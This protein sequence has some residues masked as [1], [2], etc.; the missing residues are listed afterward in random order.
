MLLQALSTTQEPS[1]LNV[2]T[3]VLSVQAIRVGTVQT[4]TERIL[5]DSHTERDVYRVVKEWLELYRSTARPIVEENAF[6]RA[7]FMD[8]NVQRHWMAKRD[9]PLGTPRLQDIKDWWRAW[10][11]TN[12][13]RDLTVDRKAGGTTRGY[14][15]YRALELNVQKTK[16]F[17]S[18]QGLPGMGPYDVQPGDEIYALKGCKALVLVRWTERDELYVMMVVGLCFVDKW[19]YGRALQGK[20]E[21]ETLELY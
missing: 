3:P 11:R 15:H 21:W 12:D 1:G 17:M 19:M 6:W 10:S 9:R 4:C 2:K 5:P 7:V 16:F 20:T 18:T 13:R 8:R 14:F